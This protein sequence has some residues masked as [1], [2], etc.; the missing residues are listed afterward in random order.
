MRVVV[1]NSVFCVGDCISNYVRIVV[2]LLSLCVLG[3]QFL[4]DD[5]SVDFVPGA[6][7]IPSCI[8]PEG[9]YCV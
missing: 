3:C 1:V 9:G 2:I 4:N 5:P 8:S 7:V 6:Q